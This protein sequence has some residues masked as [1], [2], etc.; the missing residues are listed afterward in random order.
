MTYLYVVGAVLLVLVWARIL[1]CE[2]VAY[3]DY[4]DNLM[5]ERKKEAERA[6]KLKEQ[7]KAFENRQKVLRA[8]EKLQ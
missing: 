2:H 4:I 3:A 7:I 5:D 6:S 1:L 8:L